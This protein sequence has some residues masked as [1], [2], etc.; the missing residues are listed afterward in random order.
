MTVNHIEKRYHDGSYLANNPDWDRQDCLWKSNLVKHVLN[1]FKINL[2]SVC[3]IG[4][5][6]GDVLV[7]LKKSYPDCEYTGYDIS[8]Q[9]K[10]FWNEHKADGIRFYCGDFQELNTQYYDCILLLDVIEH[11]SDPFHFL[12]AIQKKAKYFVFH[13]PLDL[14]ASTVLREKTL[15]NART[16]VGHIHYFTKGLALALLKDANFNILHCQ[17]TKAYWKGQ[18]R[19]LKTRIAGLPRYLINRID[20]DFGVRLLGGETLIVL[21]EAAD[22]L[23]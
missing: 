23:T 9:A 13:F 14:S 12:D 8:P 22:S 11:L 6:T 20:K 7:H 17:Y 10:Q 1:E 21:A 4:C 2:K 19:G 3:E 16:K 5:G 18:D 15:L